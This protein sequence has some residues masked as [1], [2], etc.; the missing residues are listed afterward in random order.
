M[1]QESP[2]LDCS[3]CGKWQ[4]EVKKLI[5]GPTTFI[6]DECVILCFDILVVEKHRPAN[7]L[8]PEQNLLL[9]EAQLAE[10]VKLVTS[11]LASED[12][13]RKRYALI[14]ERLNKFIDPEPVSLRLGENREKQDA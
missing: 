12:E 13:R 8:S 3:F 2:R 10:I 9:R 4:D 11:V 14:Q 5:A 7:E 1:A 6:C